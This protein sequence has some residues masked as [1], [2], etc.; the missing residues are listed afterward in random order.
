[1]PIV[2]TREGNLI[3]LAKA[4]NYTEIAHGCNCFHTF[5]AG[6]APQIGKAFPDSITA[7]LATVKGSKVKLGSLSTG[8]HWLSDNHTL[9]I[10][11]MYTQHGFGNRE[12]GLPDIEYSAVRKAFTILNGLVR[13]KKAEGKYK[14]TQL[15]GIPMIGAGLAGGHWEAIS[16]IIDLVTPD[17]QIELVK[18]VP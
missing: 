9:K 17:V 2:S 10:V 7:D 16:T 3:E 6:I 14:R 11:N 18:F 15:L 12:I 1:M 8:L 13:E 4:G 5:G